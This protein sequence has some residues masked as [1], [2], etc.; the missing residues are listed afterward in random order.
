[1][2][3]GMGRSPSGGTRDGGGRARTAKTETSP[4]WPGGRPQ[5]EAGT[6][7]PC[8]LRGVDRW[9]QELTWRR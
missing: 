2:L 3:V 9:A 7:C 5:L 8:P 6:R 1:M 4:A